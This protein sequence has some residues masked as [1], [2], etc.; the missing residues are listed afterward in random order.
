MIQETFFPTKYM[1]KD[2]PEVGK[3]IFVRVYNKT[4]TD[5]ILMPMTVLKIYE[6][7]SWDGQCVCGV[8]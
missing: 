6:D 7:G 5:Y 4:D 3:T 8:A 1:T 2:I